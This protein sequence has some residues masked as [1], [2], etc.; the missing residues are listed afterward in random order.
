M[1]TKQLKPGERFEHFRIETLA[2]GLDDYDLSRHR[3]AHGPARGHQDSAPGTRMRSRFYSR[4]Q[5][6]MAI[7]KKLHHPGVVQMLDSRTSDQLCIV[8]EWVDGRFLREIL[9]R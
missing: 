8:M 5:R 9:D 4:F 7:G 3:P 2:A 1:L 6:E